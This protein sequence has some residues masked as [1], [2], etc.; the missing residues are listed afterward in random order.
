MKGLTLVYSVEIVVAVR[1]K[2][3]RAG[4]EAFDGQSQISALRKCE[5][6]VVQA[7][8]KSSFFAI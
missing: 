5:L 4:I 7:T 6:Q 8:C 1:L 2:A 3:S